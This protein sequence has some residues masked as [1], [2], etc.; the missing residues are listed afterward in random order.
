MTRRRWW[1]L[2]TVAGLALGMVAALLVDTGRSSSSAT[3]ESDPSAA[4]PVPSPTTPIPTVPPEAA[5]SAAPVTATVPPVGPTVDGSSPPELLIW[6][7]NGLVPSLGATLRTMPAVAASTI[8]RGDDVHLT[9]SWT[10]DG[11]VIDHTAPGWYLPLDAFAVDPA[12]YASVVAGG[13]AV[14]DAL[15]TPGSAVLGQTSATL[16][17]ATVGSRL[18]IGDRDLLTVTAIVPDADV[19]AAELVVSYDTGVQLGITTERAALV[20]YTGDRVDLERAVT[21]SMPKGTPTR[22][23]SPGET[24]YLRHGDAVLPQS[25]VKQR[26]GEFAVHPLD[27]TQLELDPAW[28]SANIVVA[29]LPVLGRTQC[30]RQIVPMVQGA[31]QELA[32][33]GLTNLVDPAQFG[34][35]YN[36]RLIGPGLGIS[37]HTW[38]IALDVNVAANPLGGSGRQDPRLVEI[39]RRWG[40]AWGGDWLRPDPM[41]FEYL[42]PPR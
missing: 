13:A 1:V 6:S 27:G 34:G 17:R 8:V 19:A 18:Q 16:R 33:A 41:H 4:D 30:N 5:E 39:M 20:R 36:P 3:G 26:F 31:L 2:L 22:F 23:R 12:S 42:T 7:T 37:R 29:T 15:A 11:A 21:R 10:P 28:V 32:D 14:A 35:C 38:G 24:T 40:L 25:L 9:A